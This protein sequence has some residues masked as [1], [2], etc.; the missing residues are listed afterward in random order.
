MKDDREAP[1]PTVSTFAQR[2]AL[3]GLTPEQYADSLVEDIVEEIRVVGERNKKI[4]AERDAAA[5]K[6][7]A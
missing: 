7:A 6:Q 3:L 2:A 1:A 5:A 4:L